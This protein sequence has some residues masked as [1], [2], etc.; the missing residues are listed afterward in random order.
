VI[1]VAAAL[2]GPWTRDAGDVYLKL[3]GDLYAASRYVLPEELPGA[4]SQEFGAKG[5]FAQQVGLY[6]EVGLSDGH[7]I[8][9]AVKVPFVASSV[10][11][12]EV[13]SAG[14]F[15]GRALAS[16]F[17]D[18]EFGPQVALSRKHPIA[19]RL[20]W[21]V[22]LYSVDGICEQSV[23]RDYCG[24]P[25]DGQTDLTAWLT[26]GSSFAGGRAWV[27]A[28]LGYRHRT[29]I[30][31][32]WST[33]RTFVDGVAYGV[34]VGGRIGP[35]IGMLR[36]D[37]VRN[38]RADPWTGDGMHLGPSAMIEVG[39]GFALEARL[40]V[41]LLVRNGTSG[42]GGGLGVSWRRTP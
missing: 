6:A 10:R 31:R 5:I 1:L 19:A 9:L 16:R 21:K 11:F 34:A 32:A 23:F 27:E 12:A 3:A 8:Q 18:L 36:A 28:E 13:S 40:A 37:G 35:A 29:E 39:G 42:L 22:P 30:F 41:D 7:P 17:G 2:A 33:D 24:R 20:W 4:G 15:S 26:A 14:S 38:L 25:G